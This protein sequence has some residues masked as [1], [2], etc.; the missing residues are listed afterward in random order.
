MS[1]SRRVPTENCFIRQKKDNPITVNERIDLAC[2]PGVDYVYKVKVVATE[3]TPSH[4]NYIMSIVSVIKMGTDE[5]PSGSNRTFVSHKQCRDAL[6][7]QMGQDYLVWGLAS[8]LWVT[9]S[10]FSYLIG[11]DTWL[12]AWPLEDSCQDPDLQP[13]CQDFIEFSDAMTIFG[14]PT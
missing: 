9:G 13:L 6:S 2:K 10:R 3:E 5:D 8:D 14:C 12:E 11:K 7:L 1:L 4:D